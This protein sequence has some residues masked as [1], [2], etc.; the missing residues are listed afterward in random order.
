MLT[1][2]LTHMMGGT[3]ELKERCRAARPG[4]GKKVLLFLYLHGLQ[5]KGS[6]ISHDARF[7]G[8]P[9]FP[10]GPY[11]VFVSGAA[12]IGRDCVIFQHVSIGSNTLVDSSGMGAPVIGDNCYIGIGAK[13]IGKV[14]IG[15][16]VR[17]GANAVVY[18]DVPANSVIVAPQRRLIQKETLQNNRFYQQHNGRWE[19]FE[20][21]GWKK[22][23]DRE[24]LAKLD[25]EFGGRG[26]SS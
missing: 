4:L 6:W 21:G 24:I 1:E 15:D 3:W 14:R 25:A 7:A 5:K 10:H 20:G 11:G 12:V 16:N 17:I 8:K 9:C 19:F 2:L 22:E 26:P 23:N 13:I 18:T